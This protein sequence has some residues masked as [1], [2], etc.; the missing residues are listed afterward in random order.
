[1]RTSVVALLFAVVSLAACRREPAIVI[2]FDPVDAQPARDAIVDVSGVDASHATPP[3]SAID[4]TV[5]HPSGQC[6]TDEDC[7][8]ATDGCCDCANGGKLVATTKRAAAQQ[9]KKDCK[10][11]LCTMMISTDPSCGKRPACIGGTC[12]LREARPDERKPSGLK[13]PQ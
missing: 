9:S 5:R 4:K 2:R 13:L 7:A 3:A 11:V 8:V 12:G 6:M 10:D 1:M